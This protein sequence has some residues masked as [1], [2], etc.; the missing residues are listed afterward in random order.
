MLY[1]NVR[2]VQNSLTLNGS[3][4]VLLDDV[5]SEDQCSE[6]KFLAHVSVFPL[7][8]L[9]CPNKHVPYITVHFISD[10]FTM[11]CCNCC[12]K[13]YMNILIGR[14]SL[15]LVTVT[16]GKCLLTHPMRN[17]KGRQY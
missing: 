1:D 6:L 15:Q 16:R 4:R 3:Q 11:K 12:W 14:V 17:L 13:F 10:D 9:V 2:L 5:I 7:L 8:V